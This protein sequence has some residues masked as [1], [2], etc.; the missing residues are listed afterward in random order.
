MLTVLF[1]WGYIFVTAFLIGFAVL[2]PF[3]RGGAAAG[4]AP[5]GGTGTVR[6]KMTAVLMAGLAAVTVYIP[7]C[8]AFLR[9]WGFGQM[10]CWW[11]RVRSLRW[12][13]AGLWLF[14]GGKGPVNAA[15]GTRCFWR[16]W[17]C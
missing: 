6:R 17:S 5:G 10:C 1:N 2:L 9:E 14:I 11:R 3:E 7:R 13:V 8:T 16:G 4:R 15:G 12:S